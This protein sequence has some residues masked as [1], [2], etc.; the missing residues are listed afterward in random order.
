M[1]H[2]PG[3]TPTKIDLQSMC[4]NP[5]INFIF[6]SNMSIVIINLLIFECFFSAL[7]IMLPVLWK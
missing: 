2:F 1:F 3:L 6:G 4:K 5:R 7:C